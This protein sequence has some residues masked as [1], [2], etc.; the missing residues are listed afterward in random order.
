M[1]IDELDQDSTSQD[2]NQ[3][4]ANYEELFD[5]FVEI[6]K[7]YKEN[8]T[9]VSLMNKYLE[10][11]NEYLQVMNDFKNLDQSQWTQEQVV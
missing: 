11:M 10:F 4:M 8:L 3:I 1:T 9:D 5:K 7:A 2:F 6:S